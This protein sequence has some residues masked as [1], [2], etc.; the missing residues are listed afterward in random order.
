MLLPAL[1][2]LLSFHVLRR[3]MPE[4]GIRFL[5]GVGPARAARLG[6]LG[7]YSREDLLLH[8][9]RSYIDRRCITRIADLVPGR[10]ATV[11]GTVAAS[12]SWRSKSGRR[13]FRAEL[14]DGSGRLSITFFNTAFI[15]PRL[16]SG[17]RIMATGSITSFRGAGM[18][19]PE[20]VQ[21]DDREGLDPAAVLP[22]YPLTEGLTQ[23]VVRMLVARVLA[24]GD[25]HLPELLPAEVL[26]ELGWTGRRE[27]LEKV[28]LPGSPEEGE[29]A[30]RTLALE[31][32]Y[33][34]Q[35]VLREVRRRSD[36]V[37]GIA[38][39]P[40][41][42]LLGS[43]ARSLPWR[44]TPSQ[45]SCIRQVTAAMSRSIPMR[46]L[47]Q[48]DVG[49][50]KTVVA[51]A[52]CLACCASGRQAVVAAPTEVLA[53]QHHRTLEA[54]LGPHGV[55]C[56]LITGGTPG[57]MRSV[58]D[59]AL[60]R[61][62]MGVLCGTHALFEET[63]N[64]PGLGLCIIDE[65]HKFGVEQR[66]K[67]LEGLVPRPHMM[68]MSATP[69]PRT[70]AMTIYGDLDMAVLDGMPPGRGSIRT[71]IMS[72][73]QRSEVFRILEE[74]LN[75]G[76]RAYIVYP[77]RDA[78]SDGDLRD[79]AS[80]YEVLRTGS[81]GRF[82]VGLLTG[83]MKPAEKLETAG[84]FVSGEITLLVS[85]TVIEV[86]IDVPEAT[87]MVVANAERFGLSQLHQLRGRVGRGG[88][89]SWCFLMKGTDT[90]REALQRLAILEETC[91][92]FR[93]AARDLELRGPGEIVGTRQHGL[94]SFRI[95]SLADDADLVEKAALIAGS[96]PPSD[97][98]RSEFERRFGS[99]APP[100]V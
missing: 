27:V 4:C 94:P 5:S 77:L 75:L 98:V 58:I 60:H 97:A 15:E 63:V 68:I 18:V 96:T 56:G 32:L 83:A 90:G 88:N 50:G 69:I 87:V 47:L 1:H 79:A 52:A 21:E 30:R 76:E 34:Y 70:L 44:L 73:E 37:P 84:R 51:A 2:R 7:I 89:D 65:Q 6:K 16:R 19:H 64:V 72:R 33:V 54:L 39:R 80:S 66:E 95:A 26:G 78:S 14:E 93:I 12:G 57:S 41:G 74:R 17:A 82:G 3:I 91:D 11:S 62:E 36:V 42:G 10:S 92:G 86:G 38:L 49:S 81:L 48:G 24:M 13:V 40:P 71:L 43:F 9:P 59:E 25:L 28:H 31:E 8:I 23:G 20:I 99:A 46:M 53:A 29:K 85:T 61:G 67:L 55:R 45:E 35:S 100:G 22:V